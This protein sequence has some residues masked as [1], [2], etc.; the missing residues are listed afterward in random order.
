[1]IVDGSKV[2]SALNRKTDISLFAACSGLK[3]DYFY[4]VA[5][6]DA[7]RLKTR[8]HSDCSGDV[9]DEVVVGRDQGLCVDT[10][11]SVASLDIA[12]AGNCPSGQVQISYWEQAGCTGKWFGYSYASRDTCRSLWTQG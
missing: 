8:Y 1:M 3:T 9:H 12:S 11:C 7:F 4:C 6:E 10:G 2:P 5:Q